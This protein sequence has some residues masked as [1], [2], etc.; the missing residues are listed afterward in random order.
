MGLVEAVTRHNPCQTLKGQLATRTSTTVS[1]QCLGLVLRRLRYLA[2]FFHATLSLWGLFPAA[3]LAPAQHSQMLHLHQSVH[4]PQT[5]GD[6]R[7]QTNIVPS[8]QGNHDS[9]Q[10]MV[11]YGTGQ[12]LQ[13]AF[14]GVGN[15]RQTGRQTDTTSAVATSAA[16]DRGSGF[17][18]K[19]WN[20][21]VTWPIATGHM[22]Q[23]TAV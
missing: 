21:P 1:C 6:R 22:S 5:A 7:Q 16:H 13:H 9:N 19:T 11:C 23:A 12:Q 10:N 2:A 8:W 15:R 14:Q 17:R 18:V 20:R 4:G 3:V